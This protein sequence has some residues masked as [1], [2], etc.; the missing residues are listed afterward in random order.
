[1]TNRQQQ[2][3]A[4]RKK[5]LDTAELM[6]KEHKTFDVSVDEI[7]AKCGVAKGTFY[8]YFKT[9]DA[10]LAEIT[11]NSYAQMKRRFQETD[12]VTSY[13][14]RLRMFLMDWYKQAAELGLPFPVKAMDLIQHADAGKRNGTE[15]GLEIIL[16][17]LNGAVS[18]GELLPGVPVE[19]LALTI[20][21]T[22]H[23]SI[24]HL[25]KYDADFDILKW[26]D[27]L[28]GRILDALLRSWLTSF[29]AE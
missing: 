22:M 16:E 1:M 9:K 17:C 14:A 13:I 3:L 26:A 15:K 29:Q 18:C 27:V 6:M 7:V 10:F 2:A 11:H 8:H 20:I 23:G 28:S 24:L 25:Q 19:D 12:G 21:F 4:T 5:L